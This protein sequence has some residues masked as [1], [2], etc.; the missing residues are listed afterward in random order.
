MNSVLKRI[1]KVNGSRITFHSNL[2]FLKYFVGK[3]S[4]IVVFWQGFRGPDG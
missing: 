4:L 1:D 3:K 2:S